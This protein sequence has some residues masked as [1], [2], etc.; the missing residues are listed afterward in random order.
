MPD[1]DA[2]LWGEDD[3]MPTHARVRAFLENGASAESL[4]PTRSWRRLFKS[5]HPIPSIG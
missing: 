1:R 5:C 3:R 2:E 4:L